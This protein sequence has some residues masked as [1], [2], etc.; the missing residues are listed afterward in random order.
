M[1]LRP[2]RL[3]ALVLLLASTALAGT[4][5][6]NLNYTSNADQNRNL[7]RLDARVPAGTPML[8]KIFCGQLANT[9]SGEFFGP[10]EWGD[11]TAGAGDGAGGAYS[12]GDTVCNGLDSDTETTAD[13]V[14]YTNIPIA[15]V[16]MYCKAVADAG[17]TGSGNNG[18]TFTLRA[19]TNDVSPSVSC[20]VATGAIDCYAPG[21]RASTGVVRGTLPVIPAGVAVAIKDTTDEN[22]SANDGW[23]QLFYTFETR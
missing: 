21:A 10:A 22:L 12:A 2:L 3:F 1:R 17:T 16:G 14:L 18:V 8:S 23:C 15:I 11:Q 20:T 9:T 4:P 6:H 5:R 19:G 13:Q 7:D